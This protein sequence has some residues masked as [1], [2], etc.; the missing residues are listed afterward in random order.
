[1]FRKKTLYYEPNKGPIWKWILVFGFMCALLPF[2]W[3]LKF[4]V[5]EQKAY[6]IAFTPL[7]KLGW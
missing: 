5:E 7:N 4:F 6:D 3:F 2:V 1:M